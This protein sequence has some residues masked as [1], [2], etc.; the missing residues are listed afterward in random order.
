[1]E[2]KLNYYEIRDMIYRKL[3]SVWNPLD[4]LDA[5]IIHSGRSWYVRLEVWI[6]E[7][8]V[9]VY[10]R[11]V[12]PSSLEEVLVFDII[13]RTD[14]SLYTKMRF[15][16]DLER[17]A[18]D[19]A[20]VAVSHPDYLDK[21]PRYCWLRSHYTSIVVW[22]LSDT[23]AIA[24]EL[25]EPNPDY[26]SAIYNAIA[27]RDLVRLYITKEGGKL[28]VEAH[29]E[30]PEPNVCDAVS[31]KYDDGAVSIATRLTVDDAEAI[32]RAL[33]GFL[34]SP[35]IN[36]IRPLA[37]ALRRPVMYSTTYQCR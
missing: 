37:L 27:G 1:M 30:E 29:P 35:K 14:I 12:L 4:Y 7:R 8:G 22:P 31:L 5:H 28:E 33:A 21:L 19:L 2:T 23:G 36:Y 20:Y 3:I 13:E 34:T 17:V 15:K 6:T 26:Y 16:E 9:E 25:P 18:A 10:A 32:S 24:A 11:P